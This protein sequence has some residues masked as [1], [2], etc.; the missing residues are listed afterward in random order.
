MTPTDH[1][2]EALYLFLSVS[3]LW[4]VWFRWREYRIDALRQRFFSLRDDLFDLASSGEVS[5]DSVTYTYLRRKI[6]GMIRFAHRISFAR[7]V[8]SLIVFNIA[9]KLK[10]SE[11]RHEEWSASVQSLNTST[12]RKIAEINQRVSILVVQHMVLGSPILCTLL[13]IFV[14]IAAVFVAAMHCWELV[15]KRMPGLDLIEAQ[16]L[17]A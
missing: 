11:D 17:K 9:G 16:A 8:T 15:A 6:N 13:G 12:K 7:L 5:F 1:L 2:A 14:P 10:F 3:L 4:I